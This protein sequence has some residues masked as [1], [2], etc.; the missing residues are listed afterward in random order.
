MTQPQPQHSGSDQ[1]TSAL[2]ALPGFWDSSC[3]VPTAGPIAWLWHGYLARGNVTLLTSQWKSGKTTLVAVLLARMAAGGNLAGLLV[4]PG[5]VVVISEECHMNWLRRSRKLSFGNNVSFLCRPFT[6]KPTQEDW[7][8][9]M[10]TLVKLHQF[11][12]K[13]ANVEGV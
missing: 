1:R 12:A 7:E 13:I 8:T 11:S 10:G 2:A 6:G 5:K 4:S 9:L 3:S